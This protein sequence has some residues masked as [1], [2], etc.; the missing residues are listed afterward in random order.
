MKL[1]HLKHK[2]G[3]VCS[4]AVVIGNVCNVQVDPLYVS[5]IVLTG[6]VWD[7]ITDPIIGYLSLKTKTRFGRLR[8][9]Y[10]TTCV[11]LGVIV[12]VTLCVM[13]CV[14]VCYCV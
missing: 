7:A 6:R 8:P 3:V 9:W 14:T 4:N 13:L 12:C 1:F 5:A 10:V 2:D 11:I